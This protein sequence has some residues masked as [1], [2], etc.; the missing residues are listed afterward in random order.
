MVTRDF[1]SQTTPGPNGPVARTSKA[2]G[3]KPLRRIPSQVGFEGGENHDVTPLTLTP[4][5]MC[6]VL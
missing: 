6:R 1:N 5:P 2:L 3:N 4:V